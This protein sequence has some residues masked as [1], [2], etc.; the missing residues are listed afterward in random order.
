[1]IP[2]FKSICYQLQSQQ[3]VK[4]TWLNNDFDPRLHLLPMFPSLS[5]SLLHQLPIWNQRPS[6]RFCL[7]P[8]APSSSSRLYFSSWNW[9]ISLEQKRERQRQTEKETDR[10]RPICIIVKQLAVFQEICE[11]TGGGGER[12]V[13]GERT[14][15]GRER[16]REREMRGKIGREREMVRKM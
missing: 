8:D 15:D 6:T 13:D 9:T 14:I 11:L 4:M 1:M 5:G 3:E 2:V 7:M 16:E 12:K 10:W